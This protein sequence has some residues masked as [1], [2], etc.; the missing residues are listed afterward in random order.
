[1]TH[2]L[3]DPEVVQHLGEAWRVAR[4]GILI[5]DL[6]RGAILYGMLWLMFCLMRFPAHFRADALLSVRRGFLTRELAA[7]AAKAGIPNAD[8]SLYFGTRVLLRAKK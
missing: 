2:H 6:H 1:M 4:S 5:S 3:S 8:V 7:M